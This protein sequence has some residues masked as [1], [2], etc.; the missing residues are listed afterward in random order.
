MPDNTPDDI[1]LSTDSMEEMLKFLKELDKKHS[2]IK[3]KDLKDIKSGLTITPTS[4]LT[5]VIVLAINKD[6]SKNNLMKI[7]CQQ[8]NPI[9]GYVYDSVTDSFSVR[10]ADYS[11]LGPVAAAF[12]M[13]M[14]SAEGWSAYVPMTESVLKK[15]LSSEQSF[16]LKRFKEMYQDHLYKYIQI[17]NSV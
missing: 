13:S 17:I 7:P 1:L 5:F 14:D 12:K 4:D 9:G 2:E 3:Q 16:C 10:C 11:V 6:Y 8:G 15:H